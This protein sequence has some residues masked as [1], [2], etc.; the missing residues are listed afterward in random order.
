MLAGITVSPILITV[1]LVMS[2]IRPFG[3]ERDRLCLLESSQNILPDFGYGLAFRF[4]RP[5]VRKLAL[6]PD[7]QT[8]KP[9]MR[10]IKPAN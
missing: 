3:E 2:T 9:G 10:L 6:L 7:H 1:A 4:R 5:F 8:K